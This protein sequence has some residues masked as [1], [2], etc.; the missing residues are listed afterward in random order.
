MKSIGVSRVSVCIRPV[1]VHAPTA[2]SSMPKFVVSVL[3]QASIIP[4]S[5]T[6]RSSVKVLVVSFFTYL[7]TEANVGKLDSNRIQ[8][9]ATSC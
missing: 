7:T 8:I 2:R 9:T 4:K 1:V 6:D 3:M 5:E